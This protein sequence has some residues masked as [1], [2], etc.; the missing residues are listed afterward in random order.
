ME[1]G[2][3]NC[4]E[5]H[6][7]VLISFVGAII[8][9]D[10]TRGSRGMKRGPHETKYDKDESL[11]RSRSYEPSLDASALRSAA[12]GRRLLPASGEGMPPRSRDAL[13]QDGR[14]AAPSTRED[15]LSSEPRSLKRRQS[16]GRSTVS[17]LTACARAP[18]YVANLLSTL[19]GLHE[20]ISGQIVTLRDSNKL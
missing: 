3:F 11:S 17:V 15:S 19:S 20:H 7:C 2:D 10:A 13:T 4:E 14:Q 6:T 18:C 9:R 8:Q 1:I 5:H 12:S 16:R